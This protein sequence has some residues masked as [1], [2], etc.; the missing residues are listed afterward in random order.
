MSLKRKLLKVLNCN[1]RLFANKYKEVT[2]LPTVVQP[3]VSVSIELCSVSD[4]FVSSSYC[5][6]PYSDLS[7][8]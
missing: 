5:L 3:D 1:V 7:M 2:G 4:Y 8:F 6:K